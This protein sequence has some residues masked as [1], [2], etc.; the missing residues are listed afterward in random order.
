MRHELST[1]EY[2]TRRT[3][4]N[5]VAKAFGV[6]SLRHV[7]LEQ[8]ARISD[9]EL[10]RFTSDAKVLRKR[11]VHVITENERVTIAYFGQQMYASHT[12]LRDD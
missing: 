8:L 2:A 1:S 4:C 5:A 12:S 9:Q 7:T 11:A 10:E 3:Q 6:S